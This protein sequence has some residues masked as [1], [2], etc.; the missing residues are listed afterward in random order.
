MHKVL[1]CDLDGV[2][3]NFND[4]YAE[5]FKKYGINFPKE[6]PEYPSMWDWE[7]EL[8]TPE[9]IK[10]VWKLIN[11][12]HSYQFWRFL[13]PY[14]GAKEFLALAQQNF[15]EVAFVTSRPGR[16]AKR[17]TVDALTMLG[18]PSPNV[19]IS[20]HKVPDLITLGATDFVDDRDKNFE[21][22]LMYEAQNYG[23]LPIR[24]RMYDKPWNRHFN[25]PRVERIFKLEELL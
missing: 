24:L 21:D 6:S 8:A 25:H 12:P 14:K 2:I 5:M 4:A 16:D 20:H 15:D 22:I 1:A 7:A 3:F 10:E 19:I 9:Q 13:T 11:G 23:T 17:A 18:V